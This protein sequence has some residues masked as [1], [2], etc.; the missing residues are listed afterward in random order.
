MIYM[1]PKVINMKNIKPFQKDCAAKVLIPQDQIS[2][3]LS[4]NQIIKTIEAIY[5]EVQSLYHTVNELEQH[6]KKLEETFNL[7]AC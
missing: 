3:T 6:L 4:S 5:N 7:L 1:K 2:N